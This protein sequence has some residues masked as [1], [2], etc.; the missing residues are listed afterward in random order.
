M[1]TVPAPANAAEAL[2]ML[3]AGMSY[4]AAADP[5][6]MAAQTHFH[7]MPAAARRPAAGGYPLPASHP[8]TPGQAGNEMTHRDGQSM[9]RRIKSIRIA[10]SAL[11]DC[12][13]QVSRAAPISAIP[14]RGPSHGPEWV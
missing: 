1:R 7:L 9:R 11:E 8:V 14:V 5:T 6:A 10:D 4:L 2:A 13:V 3:R 12:Q